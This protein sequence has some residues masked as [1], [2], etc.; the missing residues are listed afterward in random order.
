[1]KKST[2]THTA[3]A[4]KGISFV[5]FMTAWI[6]LLAGSSAASLS[7]TQTVLAWLA[8]PVGLGILN[9]SIETAAMV[10]GWKAEAKGVA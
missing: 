5:A 10:F 9:A 1:M 8:L 3:M 4:V 7:L 2:L 6:A